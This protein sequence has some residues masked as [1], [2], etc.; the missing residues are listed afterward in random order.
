MKFGL[1]YEHQLPRP[2]GPDSEYNRFQEAL[3]QVELADKVGVDYVWLVEHHFLE[4]YAHSSAP[5]IFL[6]GCSQRTK[7]IRLG[8]GIVALPTALQPSGARRGADFDARSDEQRP[9][10]VWHRRDLVPTPSYSLSTCR[11]R[12]SRRCGWSRLK[13]SPG[14]WW[15]SRSG[16]MRANISTSRC[17]T[18]SPSRGRSRIRR[19]GSRARVWIPSSSRRG[20]DWER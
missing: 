20:S 19:C 9:G 6:A 16:D 11:A 4:E 1:F 10:R 17:A 14:C 15:K 7:Q 3:D 18:S 12:K 2:W 13:S 5:E 8:H